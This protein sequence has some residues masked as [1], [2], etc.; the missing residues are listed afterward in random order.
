MRSSCEG[1]EARGSLD[2]PC[3]A[4]FAG[5]RTCGLSAVSVLFTT[6]D[7]PVIGDCKFTTEGS[8]V[9][10]VGECNSLLLMS[11]ATDDGVVS[12]EFGWPSAMGGS[13][14]MLAIEA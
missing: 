12:I 3:A 6:L 5:Q 11:T 9:E 2:E 8:S 1:T 7:V 4:W 13:D 10:V 14:G